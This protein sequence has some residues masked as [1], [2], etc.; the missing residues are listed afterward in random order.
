M[1]VANRQN[2][3]VLVNMGVLADHTTGKPYTTAEVQNAR[4]GAGPNQ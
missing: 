3:C 4:F 2:L 1:T